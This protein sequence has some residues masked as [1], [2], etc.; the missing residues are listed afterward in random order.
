MIFASSRHFAQGGPKALKLVAKILEGIHLGENVGYLGEAVDLSQE[1]VS[2]VLIGHKGMLE[3]SADVVHRDEFSSLKLRN[4]RLE[5]L[6]EGVK[7]IH[8]HCKEI[9]MINVVAR[10]CIKCFMESAFYIS[11]YVVWRE[12]LGNVCKD[13][14]IQ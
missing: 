13:C 11:I 12:I 6:G 14:F 9:V 8:P 1:L 5:L 10:S 7:A 3:G 2:K 4:C